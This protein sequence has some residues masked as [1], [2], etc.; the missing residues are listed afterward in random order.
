LINLQFRPEGIGALFA[1]G[2]E[3]RKKC[4][5]RNCQVESVVIKNHPE[6]LL[7]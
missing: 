7:A 2:A 6:K 3:R 5:K 4:D 1:P